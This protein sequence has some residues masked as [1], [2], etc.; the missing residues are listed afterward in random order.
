MGRGG[1]LGGLPY[2]WLFLGCL[3]YGYLSGVWDPP[4]SSQPTLRSSRFSRSRLRPRLNWTR[5]SR[6]AFFFRGA[7]GGDF[8]VGRT[9]AR[10]PTANPAMTRGLLRRGG[11]GPTVGAV[12]MHTTCVGGAP[13]ICDTRVIRGVAHHAAVVWVSPANVSVGR[14]RRRSRAAWRHRETM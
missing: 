2:F 6:G 4:F 10:N 14:S 11:L 9:R 5:Q 8:P 7:K 3:G 13:R 12:L 1:V